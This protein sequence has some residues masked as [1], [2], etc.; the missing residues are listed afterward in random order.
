MKRT[1]K[2]IRNIEKIENELLDNKT[3]VITLHLA[4]DKFEQLAT[5]FL[6]KD[7]NIFLFFAQDDELYENIQFGSYVSF[8]ILRNVRVRRTKRADFF[9]CYRFFSTK[10]SGSI[11]KVEEKKLC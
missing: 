4:E 7:K 9:P 2:Q 8:T 5:P 10:I 3:G 11:R 6:Y 1:I